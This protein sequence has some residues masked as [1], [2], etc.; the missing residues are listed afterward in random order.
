MRERETPST[1]L[2]G[3]QLLTPVFTIFALVNGA[4]PH[5][6][7]RLLP[8]P[9]ATAAAA[10][11]PQ[12]QFYQLLKAF[13]L[14]LLG[15]FLSALATL[16]FS[17][18]LLVGLLAAPL[19]FTPVSASVSGSHTN[20]NAATAAYALLLHALSPPAVLAAAVAL[21]R[22]FAG[23]GAGVGE[24]GVADVLREAAFGWDV[25]GLYTPLIVWCVWWPAWLVGFVVLLG[26]SAAGR[27]EGKQKVP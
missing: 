21:L 15:M 1:N 19:T 13:S 2:L 24:I 16:N 6:L 4:L 5:L 3:I 26:A 27:R 9:S 12:Q 23:A 14:L 18:A 17:L 25:W 22:V 10:A 20:A 11:P 8:A 7:S